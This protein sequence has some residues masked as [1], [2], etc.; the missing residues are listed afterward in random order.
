MTGFL[1]W[2]SST[3]MR[4][5]NS[6]TAVTPSLR[7]MPNFVISK[8]ER[9]WPTSVTSVPWRVVTSLGGLAPSISWARSPAMAWGMA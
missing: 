3:V 5:R 1:I 4:R 8:N 7:S 2:N 9:S 6:E